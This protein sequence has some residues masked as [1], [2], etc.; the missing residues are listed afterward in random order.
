MH[1]LASQSRIQG[2]KDTRVLGVKGTRILG[3]KGS[4]VRILVGA[5]GYLDQFFVN[6]AFQY[7]HWVTEISYENESGVDKNLNEETCG[8]KVVNF[9]KF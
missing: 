4:R 9:S 1:S 8:P 6:K 2:F 7:P 5:P 3:V